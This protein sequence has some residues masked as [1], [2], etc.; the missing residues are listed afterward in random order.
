MAKM[1]LEFQVFT[2]ATLDELVTHTGLTR[3]A[4]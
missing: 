3:F 2:L 4:S 1:E